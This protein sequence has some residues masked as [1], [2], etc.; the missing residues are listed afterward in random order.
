[1][2]FIGAR[3][4]GSIT[5]TT[6][7]GATCEARFAGAIEARRG[8]PIIIARDYREAPNLAPFDEAL[9]EPG[10]FVDALAAVM[11]A[12]YGREALMAAAAGDDPIIAGHA[13][14]ALGPD[15]VAVV[16]RRD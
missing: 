15:A 10:S 12:V 4:Q 13:A 9:V 7:G 14:A 6:A 16:C 5:L 11:G 8:I 1:V 3:L 2:R